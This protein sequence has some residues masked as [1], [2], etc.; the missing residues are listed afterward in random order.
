MLR[1]ILHKIREFKLRRII[2][3]TAPTIEWVNLFG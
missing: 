2:G 3:V 1:T